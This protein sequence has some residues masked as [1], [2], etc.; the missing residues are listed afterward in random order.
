M[1][2]VH[3]IIACDCEMCI[4]HPAPCGA[5]C[6]LCDCVLGRPFFVFFSRRWL[7]NILCCLEVKSFVNKS[8]ILLIMSTLDGESEPKKEKNLL[9]LYEE[10]FSDRF[11]ESDV[12]YT[13]ILQQPNPP[14]PCVENWYTRP[15]RTFDWTRYGTTAASEHY[16][17]YEIV[18]EF[19]QKGVVIGCAGEVVGLMPGGELQFPPPVKT[20]RVRYS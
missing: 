16:K 8:Q 15:K 7:I 3:C 6:S 5:D 1:Y 20:V 10:L 11:S 12:E 14:P 4:V 13:R 17:L 19:I 2:T 9:S 18:C